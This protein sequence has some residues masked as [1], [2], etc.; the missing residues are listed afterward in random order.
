MPVKGTYLAIGAGGAIL[1]W[2]GL[3]GKSVSSVLR[4]VISGKSPSGA[5]AANTIYG[6]SGYGLGIGSEGAGVSDSQLG[7]LALEYIGFPYVWG[8]APVSGATDCSGFVNMLR[9][10]FLRGSIPGYAPGTYN[11]Q[12]HGPNTL[13]WLAWN[14]VYTIPLAS[15]GPG[16]LAVWQTHMGVIVQNGA[17]AQIARMVSDLDP[18]LGTQETTVAGAAPP[19][20]ILVCKRFR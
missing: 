9:G 13:A 15:A 14:G 8:G 5:A 10:W 20:E 11:G 4:D 17:T 16:D 18:A 2:S 12:T 7:N 3:K 6:Y 19:G 1:V